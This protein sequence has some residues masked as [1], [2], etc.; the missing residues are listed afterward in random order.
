MDESALEVNATNIPEDV[1][2]FEVVKANKSLPASTEGIILKPQRIRKKILISNPKNST[3]NIILDNDKYY[4]RTQGNGTEEDLK[5]I[6]TEFFNVTE[7]PANATDGRKAK[8]EERTANVTQNDSFEPE[9]RSFSEG[10]A[11]RNYKY[12]NRKNKVTTSTTE[13]YGS[14]Q[15][16]NSYT[17]FTLG[18][19]QK[20]MNNNYLNVNE[21]LRYS[22][23][24][25]TPSLRTTTA[26]P[27]GE[28]S[29]IS[30]GTSAKNL[31]R[32]ESGRHGPVDQTD[33]IPLVPIKSS[34][35]ENY[36]GTQ[37]LNTHTT[38]P[39]TTSKP[40]TY[41]SV[42]PIKGLT[43][44]RRETTEPAI[45][46]E[47]YASSS[48]LASNSVSI[49]DLD[50]EPSRSN[51]DFW[52]LNGT[53]KSNRFRGSV[54]FRPA[55]LTNVEV[56]F[57][58][59][60]TKVSNVTG[61]GLQKLE[62]PPTETWDVTAVQEFS[63]VRIPT[64]ESSKPASTT[65]D[66]TANV[67]QETIKPKNI[68]KVQVLKNTVSDK[69]ASDN[70]MSMFKFSETEPPSNTAK[71][72]ETTSASV[73]TTAEPAPSRNGTEIALIT[74]IPTTEVKK[75]TLS[76][77]EIEVTLSRELLKT[78]TVPLKTASTYPTTTLRD[79]PTTMAESTTVMMETEALFTT[80]EPL[81]ETTFRDV[82]E[83][84]IEVNT[85]VPAEEVATH[86]GDADIGTV[87]TT[88]SPE[89]NA[90]TEKENDIPVVN[91]TG[92]PQKEDVTQQVHHPPTHPNIRHEIT[93]ENV[94]AYLKLMVEAASWEELCRLKDDLKNAIIHMLDG[95]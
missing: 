13:N 89:P 4:I 59:N 32:L 82:T 60:G 39:V 55:N 27:W 62:L 78:G 25:N 16:S 7:V 31:V 35:S 12:F 26:L 72:P 46:S 22:R 17:Y 24:S 66:K 87:Q 64:T 20:A 6:K 74:P 86:S 63:P 51:F 91:I 69:V 53:N 83:L 14:K 40:M 19:V 92:P 84:D 79:E 81:P 48:T 23:T 75:T 2:K 18:E 29:S 10:D 56:D 3:E 21:D 42:K 34:G 43:I 88:V 9:G 90:A 67:T 33:W 45:S 95:T 57:K 5:R 85:E 61:D 52:K 1:P 93:E 73:Q 49:Q 77:K 50:E 68:A 30:G 38:V 58:H 65:T 47:T 94:P 36:I 8:L 54:K 71:P 70:P 44:L 28:P 11:K 41:A 15:T 37:P 76:E 80:E